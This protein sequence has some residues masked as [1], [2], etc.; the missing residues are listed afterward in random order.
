MKTNSIFKILICIFG[1]I[2]IL[3]GFII[4]LNVDKEEEIKP[5]VV[6]DAAKFKKEY[7]K[8]NNQ[9]VKGKD[10]TYRE[11]NI[12]DNNPM[13]YSSVKDIEKLLDGKTGIV[14]L[15]YPTCPWCRNAIETLISVTMAR[16][17]SEIK[18]LNIEDM[19]SHFSVA[20]DTLKI[21]KGTDDYYK[22]LMLFDKELEEYTYIF[23]D[24]EYPTGEK[25]IYAPTVFFIKDGQIIG[26]HV[27][28]V[29]LNK[30]QSPYDMITSQQKEELSNIYGKFVDEIYE[31]HCDEKC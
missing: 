5:V 8:Y 26:K 14:Y 21:K 16:N 4:S 3:G 18:Y 31:A 12:S 17:I 6:T 20:N 10:F 7:E 23:D 11:V 1:F 22:L 9:K 25:R 24:K 13:I 30:N 19:R 29:T 15:G 2:I 27:G 28:T